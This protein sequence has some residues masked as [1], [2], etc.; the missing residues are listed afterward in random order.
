ML[1]NLRR[2]L[3]DH[4]GGQSKRQR[5]IADYRQGG[6]VP[7][8]TGYDEFKWQE[9]ATALSDPAKTQEIA[10]GTVQPEWGQRL[11]ERIVEYPWI[12]GKLTG[13]SGRLLDAGSTFNFPEIVQ[14]PLIRERDLTIFT[15][16]PERHC[17]A[18]EK[19]SYVFGDLRD[20][21]FRNHW[22]DT[23]V[24][25]S[26][27]EHVGMDNTIYGDVEHGSEVRSR[28]HLTAIQELVRVLRPG[29][30]LL[31]T[32][33]CG[34][35]EEHGFFRQF[36]AAMIGEVESLLRESGRV[37]TDYFRYR[38]Q[39]WTAAV[40]ED[41]ADAESFNPHTGRGRGDDGAA[42]CRAVCCIELRKEM[43]S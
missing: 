41:C 35:F 43:P 27:I 1:K 24:C 29:G 28:T 14:H 42:H 32:F 8:S 34:K 25:H 10:S 20:L 36:D 40:W 33:P 11:D 22:F 39:G 37:A 7:W 21:P 4:L 12:F 17:F 6:N 2:I 19:I 26:T 5:R 23:V 9:I 16:E 13:G 3:R 30:H 38:Q 15:L 18:K 31:L